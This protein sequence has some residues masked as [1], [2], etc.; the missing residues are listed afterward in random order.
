MMT[1]KKTKGTAISMPA[2]VALGAFVSLLM[3][4][5]FAAALTWFASIGKIDER[6][7]G[8]ISMGSLLLSTIAGTLV[9]AAKIKRRRMLVCCET[10]AIFFASLLAITAI[11]FG[12]KFR[13]I[14]VT[15]A[16]I[17][18]GCL[19]PGILSGVTRNNSKRRYSKYGTG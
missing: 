1:T 14:W 8:Y 9:S 6:Q 11:F 15:A 4:F 12:G 5:I 3:M 18:I 10:G 16:T 2:G 19:I 7:I 17:L 13:G